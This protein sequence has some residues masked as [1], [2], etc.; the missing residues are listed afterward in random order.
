[1]TILLL[2]IG[3]FTWQTLAVAQGPTNLG[4]VGTTPTQGIVEYDAPDDEPCRVEASLVESFNPLI[5][6]VNPALFP[7]AGTDQRAIRNGRHRTL[8]IGQRKAEPGIN[9]RMYS[10]ALQTATAHALRITCTG[11]D[12][13][14]VFYTTSTAGLAPEP[15]P[16]HAAA[17]GNFG[18]PDFDWSDRSKPVI[19]PQSGIAIYRIGDPRDFGFSHLCR[20][21][22]TGFKVAAA[23]VL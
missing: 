22:L 9:G 21:D 15:P 23:V 12:G 2:I 1:M 16:F 3:L 20:G 11:G 18:V 17:D 19:D 8:V 4:I 13:T 7:G 5:N 10:R 14:I 6:D